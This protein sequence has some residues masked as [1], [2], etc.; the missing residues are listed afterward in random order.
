MSQPSKPAASYLKAAAK[1]LRL[2]KTSSRSKGKAKESPATSP[3]S[4]TRSSTDPSFQHC[5]GRKLSYN[6]YLHHHYR[7]HLDSPLYALQRRQ[8]S[9]A[10]STSSSHSK[11]APSPTHATKH[12][13]RRSGP[14]SVFMLAAHH[15]HSQHN[16]TPSSKTHTSLARSQSMPNRHRKRNLHHQAMM[17]LPSTLDQPLDIWPSAHSK[18]P[19]TA[20]APTLPGTSITTTTGPRAMDSDHRVKK[21]QVHSTSDLN[22]SEPLISPTTT[23]TNDDND[24]D[25]DN[26]N[27]DLRIS[28]SV[29]RA[30][31]TASAQSHLSEVSMLS[32]AITA[33]GLP[34]MDAMKEQVDRRLAA[35]S[36]AQ[37]VENAHV[38][39]PHVSFVDMRLIVEPCSAAIETWVN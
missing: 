30:D 35:D 21:D 19:T 15:H 36:E 39:L 17:A 3:M 22:A 12:Q 9:T 13:H 2:Q 4:T 34:S 6:Q 25:N 31:S 8:H 16:G 5:N 32:I 26:D 29:S 11:V 18:I 38:N 10:S 33:H 1:M 27:D 7:E 20:V 14:P 24:N 37:L 23:T 28:R